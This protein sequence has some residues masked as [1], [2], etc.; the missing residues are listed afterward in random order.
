MKIH[1][2]KS[3]QE[4]KGCFGGSKSWTIVDAYYELNSEERNLLNSNKN[5]LNMKLFDLSFAG[6]DGI[7]SGESA[8]T[9]KELTNEKYAKEGKSGYPLGCFF[10]NGEIQ[11]VENLVNSGARKLKEELYGGNLGATTTEI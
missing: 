9:V 3:P 11:A 6:P 8:R 4:S 1:I 10:T 2:N 7:P 5:I